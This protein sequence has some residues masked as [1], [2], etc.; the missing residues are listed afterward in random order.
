[1]SSPYHDVTPYLTSAG[2]VGT[3][4]HVRQFHGVY[5]GIVISNTDPLNQN[6]ITMYV[7]QF[8][9]TAQSGWA[10][11][12]IG[13]LVAPQPG[14]LV[15]ASFMGGDVSQPVYINAS[16]KQ[17]NATA[18]QAGTVPAITFSATQPASGNNGDLWFNT[19][20][21]NALSQFENGAWTAYMYGTEAIAASAI[22]AKEIAA[23]ALDAASITA[24]SITAGTLTAAT[25]QNAPFP[26]TS[27]TTMQ[28]SQISMSSAGG[29]TPSGTNAG[30]S[31]LIYQSAPTSQTVTGNLGMKEHGEYGDVFGTFPVPA[32]VTS[33]SIQMW[34]GGAGG[35]ANLHGGAGGEYIHEPDYQ[36]VPLSILTYSV[37]NGGVG[38]GGTNSNTP[39]TN[40][41]ITTITGG[42]VN[43][44]PT[45]LIAYGGGAVFGIAAATFCPRSWRWCN[46]QFWG[47]NFWCA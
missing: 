13:I 14:E 10:M 27:Q 26:A 8:L 19:A 7:P 45:T 28:G 11:P 15:Y 34:G 30:G 18:L 29:A 22:T 6:R 16:Q 20:A 38:G 46:C 40:G 2:T 37:G 39:A 25:I 9:G 23:G 17:L 36:V 24:A 31:M 32:G 41:N 1:M 21:G 35:D 5:P 42:S 4:T 47:F 3:T 33:V 12:M 43:G 44:T